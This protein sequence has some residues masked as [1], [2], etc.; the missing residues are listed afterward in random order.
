[1]ISCRKYFTLNC[2]YVKEIIVFSVFPWL[3][4][5]E[6]F[7]PVL[8]PHSESSFLLFVFFSSN[9]SKLKCCFLVNQIVQFYLIRHDHLTAEANPYDFSLANAAFF[10]LSF[11]SFT[12][13]SFQLCENCKDRPIYLHSVKCV[14]VLWLS[15][16][17][18]IRINGSR[19]HTHTQSLP[20]VIMLA[21]KERE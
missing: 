3:P 18:T 12:L 5:F 14:C 15:I 16:F 17:L 20:A 10:F 8:F 21:R 7:L 13:T 11:S 2:L 9:T 4:I 6:H 1:M 19:T